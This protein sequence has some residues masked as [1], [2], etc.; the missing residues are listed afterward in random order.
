MLE[1]TRLLDAAAAGDPKAAAHLLPLVYDELRKLAAARLAAERPG[2]TLQATA[3]V[4]E[5]YLR[6]VGQG[7]NAGWNGRG[8]F[9]GAAA[10]AMRRILV[11]LARRKGRVQHGGSLHRVELE[12]VPAVGDSQADDLLALDD[13][14]AA[15]ARVEPL[16]AEVVKL[17]YFAGLTI[18]ETAA[19]LGISP[20]TAKRHWAVA[21]AWLYR[22]LSA[23]EEVGESTGNP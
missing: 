17:R 20:A 19:C 15:L 12:D 11:E 1:V 7:D 21:R 23:G 2:Q 13:A 8:H 22:H 4:H 10:E 16:K 14:L 6:L 18:D 3:L 5:A 9:F